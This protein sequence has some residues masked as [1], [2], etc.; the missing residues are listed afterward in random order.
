MKKYLFLLSLFIVYLF[1]VNKND[2]SPAISYENKYD[3][4]VSDISIYF[5]NGINSNSIKKVFDGYNSD[6][7]VY[8]IKLKDKDV[9][10]SC[11]NID[12]CL[13]EVYESEDKSFEILFLVT[14]FN[15]QEI[16]MLAYT[17][18]IVPFL[19]EN[20]LTYKVN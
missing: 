10:V 1:L 17:D 4:N 8:K 12:S 13:K 9:A 2:V 15:V 6:Y 11:S 20:D 7:Y 5:S 14:G 18:S 19:S 16:S 3:G